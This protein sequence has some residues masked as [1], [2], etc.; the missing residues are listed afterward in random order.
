[1]GLFTSDV[2]CPRCGNKGAR[3]S[4]FGS[5]KC[6]NR[7]CQHFNEPLMHERERARQAEPIEKLGGKVTYDKRAIIGVNLYGTQVTDVGLEHLKG[8]TSLQGL[9]LNSPQVTDAGLE[10]LT[11][12]SCLLTL[13]LSQTQV[14]DVGLEHLKGLTSLKEMS[15]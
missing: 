9:Y 11:G 6:P 13:D 2:D 3:R 1:M 8:L 12:L 7:A 10:H 5:V 4:L 15:I 14:T